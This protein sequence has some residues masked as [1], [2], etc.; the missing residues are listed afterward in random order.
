MRQLDRSTA[1]WFTGR[2]GR[3]PTPTRCQLGLSDVTASGLTWIQPSSVPAYTPS[4]PSATP[5][6]EMK[7]PRAPLGAA[8]GQPLVRSPLIGAHVTSPEAG[9]SALSVRYM[10]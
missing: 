10:R 3:V 1:S 8:P 7:Q 9:A 5:I 2:L 6:A 4:P